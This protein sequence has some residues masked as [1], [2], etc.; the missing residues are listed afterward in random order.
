MSVGK[1]RL[2]LVGWE[3]GDW[4][5]LHPLMDAGR[6][7][8]LQS[9][10]E[11]GASGHLAPSPPAF[12]AAAWTGIATG[13]R[14]W[15]HQVCLPFERQDSGPVPVGAGSRAAGAIW[16]V[17]SNLGRPAV[18]V[19]WP[20]THG[21][22]FRGVSV[23]DR[24]PVPTAPPGRPWPGAAAET[25]HP[26]GISPRLD[27][28]RV[29][30]EEIEPAM[31]GRFVPAWRE[32]NQ[33]RDPILAKL[34]LLLAA[35]ASMQAAATSL[36]SSEPWDF[37]AV[38]FPG[39]GMICDLVGRHPLHN[40]Q[41]PEIFR[42]VVPAAFG[43]L[44][45]MLARLVDL[46]GPEA[47]VALVSSGGVDARNAGILAIAGPGIVSDTL[48]HGARAI[49]VAPTLLA[50]LGIPPG[51]DVEGRV[52]DDCFPETPVVP[53]CPR[54]EPGGGDS[55]R[56]WEVLQQRL[57]PEEHRNFEW[58]R[59]QS[60]REAGRSAEALAALEGL[61]RGFPE[62][63]PFVEALLQTQLALGRLED[64]R[65]WIEV[66]EE[67][68]PPFFSR[69]CRAELAWANGETDVA[70]RCV[71]ELLE[72]PAR[73]SAAWHRVGML[74]VALRE[75]EA[76]EKCARVVLEQGDDEV[77][78][79]GLAESLL[80]R[81]DFQGASKAAQRAIG[82]RYAF[83]EAHLALARAFAAQGMLRVAIEAL[84]RLLLIQ[85]GDDLAR[86][87]R[88]RLVRTSGVERSEA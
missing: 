28:L 27:A 71:R 77:A 13:T 47:A 49:D 85:P 33:S 14:A 62:Y 37:A 68:L 41:T 60:L 42:E 20:A 18:V 36:L 17:A 66:A 23:S 75:W 81:R 72:F 70:R 54:G 12:S 1:R 46:A 48:V 88:K 51:D 63:P 80:R 38:R 78:W 44:D 59:V 2:L 69:L 11:N 53:A 26:P 6:M 15:R 65:E 57:S 8:A 31:I 4:E 84:D 30:P 22:A 50:W 52:L 83:P 67:M 9:L 74:L 45:A 61:A 24:F 73:S 3:V 58:N 34:R 21:G 5:I 64:A 32:I 16:E 82:I 86:A 79:L 87:Y 43:M 35:D 19:G 56:P 39:I 76:L 40:G 10:V 29:R 55:G 7:T 25:Y